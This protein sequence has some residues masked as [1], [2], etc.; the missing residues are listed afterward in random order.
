V[1][2]VLPFTAGSDPPRPTYTAEE[3]RRIAEDFDRRYRAG[4]FG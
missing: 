3:K 1:A 2:N 4:E